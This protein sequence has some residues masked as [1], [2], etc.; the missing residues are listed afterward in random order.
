[1]FKKHKQKHNHDLI[2]DGL[3]NFHVDFSMDGAATETNGVGN[4]FLSKE[5][6]IDILE[7]T[8]KDGHTINSE[9]LL[10]RSIPTSCIQYKATQ[11]KNNCFGCLYKF[12]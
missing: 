4:L 3:G 1:M 11:D 9:H 7:P 5:T 10:C 2:G 8:D 12:I 6:H